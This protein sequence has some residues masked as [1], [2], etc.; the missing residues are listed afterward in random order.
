MKISIRLSL[1]TRRR[2]RKWPP[3]DD[4]HRG[5]S[6]AEGQQYFGMLEIDGKSEVL[7]VSLYDLAGTRLYT[8]TLYPQR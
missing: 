2:R 8:D 3:P 6:P 4:K 5:R 7:T 1:L